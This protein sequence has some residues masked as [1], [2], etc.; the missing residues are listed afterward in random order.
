MAG[1]HLKAKGTGTQVIPDWLRDGFGRITVWK[2]TGSSKYNAYK[3]AA[4]KAILYSGGKPPAIAETWS[5]ERSPTS[6]ILANSVAEFLAYGSKSVDFGKFLDGLKPADANARP[7]VMNGFMALGWK[8]E[9]AAE[10]AWKKWVQTG[11]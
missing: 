3:T 5:G 10:A 2:A 8:D 11:R 1:E 6:D 4:R 9:A 7:T